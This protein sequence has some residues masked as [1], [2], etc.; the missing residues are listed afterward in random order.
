ML[1]FIVIAPCLGLGLLATACVSATPADDISTEQACLQHYE[2]DPIGR[3]RCR[4]PPEN[5][6][7]SVPDVRPQDLPIR[8]D[9]PGG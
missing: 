5:Q 9:A 8:T 3:D 2:R 7:G 6:N 1:R 4:L